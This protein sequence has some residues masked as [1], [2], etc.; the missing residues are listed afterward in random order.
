[1]KVWKYELLITDFQTVEMPMGTR[2]LTVQMQYGQPCL[3]AEVNDRSNETELR[4]IGIVG[5]GHADVP[6]GAVYIGTVQ[7]DSLVWH[8]YEARKVRRN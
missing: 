7:D 1:M 6:T 8:V 2:I 3:W 4:H 5:T